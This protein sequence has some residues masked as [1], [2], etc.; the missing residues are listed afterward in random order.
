MPDGNW[1]EVVSYTWGVDQPVSATRGDTEF[2]GGD[3]GF[4]INGLAEDHAATNPS[5]G[6]LL[7]ME[8]LRPV[9]PS[10]PSD[11]LFPTETIR[12]MELLSLAHE[13][14]ELFPLGQATYSGFE[15]VL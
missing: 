8:S 1:I 12:P 14:I 10:D 7:P 15:L 2:T 13:G 9:D 11:G 6:R 3:D 5:N 4:V